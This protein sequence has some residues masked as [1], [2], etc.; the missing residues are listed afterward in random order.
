[1]NGL[2]EGAANTSTGQVW[3][4]GPDASV[5]ISAMPVVFSSGGVSSVTLRMFCGADAATEE[6]PF[7]FEVDCKDSYTTDT[8]VYPDGEKPQFN[9]GGDSIKVVAS[10]VYLDFEG[11]DAPHF[12]PN[13][14]D[15]EGGWVNLT[16]DFLGENKS[17]NKDG[18]LVYNDEDEAGVGGYLPQLRVS[19]AAPSV[20]GGALAAGVVEGVPAL[21]P[22]G[23]KEHAVCAVV[24]AMD[25]LG[26]ESKL[27]K[28][29]DACVKF[30]DYVGEED[31]DGNTTYP[32]GLRAGLDVL[33]PTIE[34]ST[35]SPKADASSLK[36]FQVQVA[37]PGGS[38]GKSGLHSMPVLSKVEVR[39][40]DNDMLCGDDDDLKVKGGGEE[41]L[42][43]ECKLAGGVELP[44]L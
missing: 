42:T 28:D 37:D 25:L 36:E 23:T 30:A 19:T 14:N 7:V 12:K 5:E 38:T 40:A 39:D 44:V 6:D 16:V 3:Y 22:A 9:V 4:G 20:V 8:G 29:G 26:N 27:P 13:P 21:P 43:G 1:M 10:A 33:A 15:R 24:T 35:A 17:S 11:P 34:F 41:S 18:W 31:D 2:G 32:A